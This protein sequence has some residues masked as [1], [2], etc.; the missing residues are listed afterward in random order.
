MTLKRSICPVACSLDIL[1]DKWTLLV[2]RDLLLGKKTYGDFQN[3]PEKIPTNILAD[4]LKR[5][6]EHNL[7]YKVAYQKKPLRFEYL[8]T[9]SGKELKSVL[10]ELVKW[11]EKNIAGS[12]AR[13]KG[14]SS[15]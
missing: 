4:R 2:I 15:R 5:L 6:Q 8:L 1:G 11:G 13:Y 14:S 3:S 9:D 7:V 10:L 12:Q